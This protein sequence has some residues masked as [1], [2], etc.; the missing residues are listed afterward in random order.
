MKFIE[1]IENLEVFT[2]T[3]PRTYMV[4]SNAEE[5]RDA[6]DSYERIDDGSV[7]YINQHNKKIRIMKGDCFFDTLE[8]IYKS[9]LK[10]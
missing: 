5:G 6:T 4:W 1:Q 7:V 3:T 8:E 2:V 9:T 10:K